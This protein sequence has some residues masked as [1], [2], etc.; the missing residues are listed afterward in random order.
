MTNPFDLHSLLDANPDT[1]GLH[2]RN[3]NP[4]FAG[5]LRT[6]GYDVAYARG[7]GA[8]LF[9]E[10][11]ERYID[12]MGG[13]AV[14]NLGRNHPTVNDAVRQALDAGLP[15]LP[16][17]GP[18]RLAGVLARELL[19]VAPGGG[20]KGGLDTVFFANGGAEAV[21]A[22]IKHARAATGRRRIVYCSKAYHGLTF[23]ALSVSGNHEFRDGFGPMLEG[24]AEI[25]FNDVDALERELSKGDVAAFIVE[26]VQGKGVHIPDVDY[27]RRAGEAC[28]RAKAL[29]IVDEIQTGFGRTGRMFA[30]EHFG[31]VP[32][33]LVVAKA[34]TN[35]VTPVSAV[36][37]KR[38]IH[39]AV[40]PS[41][42]QC[43]RI[44]T[45]FGMNDI[46]MAAGLATLHAMGEERVVE[47]AERM[48]GLLVGRLREALSSFEMVKEVRG[49]GLMV[50]VEFRPPRSLGLRAGWELLHK[51][52][53][54]LF[55]QAIL[56]PLL[57]ERRIL[58]QVA[59]HRQDVIK[60]TPPLV[61][62]EGDVEEIVAGFVATVS[63]CHRFPGP[64]WEVGRK[65][66]S[67]ALKRFNVQSN[68]KKVAEPV[69]QDA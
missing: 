13:Y 68:G 56:M 36:L 48:G 54:S 63:A 34:L 19:R 14:F 44:Q 6:I 18:F 8:Y 49:L 51:L 11:G 5:V 33:V 30:C 40:F 27:L 17:I 1:L 25:P 52:D 67:A 10:S 66:G 60:L 46:G 28:S 3:I 15:S 20:S 21:D 45:T 24:M 38:W 62:T 23:G 69:G 4:A 53:Q 37:T 2:E 64:A 42:A 50:G 61:L 47:R 59:G 29:L 22:A 39:S 57:S 65:L 16:G 55:C 26:P 35:G 9:D 58:A 32:D 7:E 12:G 41:M 43:S 31:V